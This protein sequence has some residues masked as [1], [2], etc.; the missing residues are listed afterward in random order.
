[1]PDYFVWRYTDDPVEFPI[2]REEFMKKHK[3][4]QGW[5]LPGMDMRNGLDRYSEVWPWKWGDMAA[6]KSR[7]GILKLMLDIRTGDRVVIPK[8]DIY[9]D[10]LNNNCFTLIICSKRYD[11]EPVHLSFRDDFGH[12]VMFDEKY[13]TFYGNYSNDDKYIMSCLKGGGYIKAVNRI[14]SD[15][16][17]IDAIESLV[18]KL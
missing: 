2:V 5:G 16:N 12:Y 15:N 14:I 7:F 6:C 9:S 11:F 4:R 13:E 1:M 8:M 3:I 10:S 17:L 18:K